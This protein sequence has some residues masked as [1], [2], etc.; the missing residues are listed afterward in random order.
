[1]SIQTL[2]LELAAARRH[3][4]RVL[5]QVG[6]RW[7]TQIYSDKAAWTAGQLVTHLAISDQGQSN[8]VKA[9]ARGEELIPADFD[10]DRYNKRSVE[11]RAEMTPAEARK[12]LDDTRA[13]FNDWLDHQDEATLDLTGRH[14]SL[15]VYSVAEFLQVMAGHERT[16][17]DDIAR[18]LAI[19][20]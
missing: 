18:V 1:M 5:D 11:K 7:D 8:T 13:D 15:N 17:A 9:V 3:L 6:D 12:M 16:H 2:K 10:L 4:D 20:V 19:T 14:G